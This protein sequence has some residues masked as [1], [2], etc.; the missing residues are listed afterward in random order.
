VLHGNL[1]QGGK[2]SDPFGFHY[3]QVLPYISSRSS[4]AGIATV[5]GLDDLGVGVQVPVGSR[6]FPSPSRPD[7]LWGPPNLLPNG[8]GALSPGVKRPGCEA[9]H[10]L[11]ASAKVKK[12][13]IYT[14]TPPASMA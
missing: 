9:D 4:V 12:M 5:Y 7:P 3:D 6:I 1:S 11:P 14:S 8:Y 13:W 2:S 10:S